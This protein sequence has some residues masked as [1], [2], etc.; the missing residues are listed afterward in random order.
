MRPLSNQLAI[1]EREDLARGIRALLASPL[2]TARDRPDDFEVIRRRREPLI[3]W[4]DYFCGWALTM[5]ARAGYARLAKV[6]RLERGRPALRRRSGAAPFDRRRYTLLC[7]AAAELLATPVT[8]I[9]LLADRVAQASAADPDLPGMDTASRAERMAFV[10]A[11]RLL[12]SMGAVE[13]L[14]GATES[15]VSSTEAKVLYRVDATLLMRLIAAP[16]GPSRLLDPP[17][18]LT[19]RLDSLLHE[20]RYAGANPD[21]EPSA[22]QR[23]LGLRHAVFRRLLDDPVVHRDELSPAEIDYLTSPT[24]RQLLR[25]AAEEAGLV[26]EERSEGWLLIDPDGIA[27]DS[28]FPDDTSHPKVAALALLDRLNAEPAGVTD[29]QLTVAAD[30]LLRRHPRWAKAY[31]GEDGSRRLR[32]AALAVLEQ[33][34]LVHRSGPLV[35]VRPVA[36]RYAVAGISEPEATRP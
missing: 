35:L 14:D 25:R 3:R 12:E 15:Y 21:D 23:N 18:A 31:Q 6:R 4:F 26:L 10:D 28:R 11:L 22:V 34:G 19:D 8:T 36:A 9:G 17:A 27:T 29:E 20:A 13:V 7:V 1:A 32:D 2:L 33:F 5:E 16:N 24:G 30:H